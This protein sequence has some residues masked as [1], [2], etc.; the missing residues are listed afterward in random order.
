VGGLFDDSMTT[1]N[2]KDETDLLSTMKNFRVARRDG[3]LVESLGR[4]ILHYKEMGKMG[5]RERKR[6]ELRQGSVRK[7]QGNKWNSDHNWGGRDMG[8]LKTK[9]KIE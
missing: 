6:H 3:D 2:M 5:S 4:K 7:G 9:K 8:F 1:L